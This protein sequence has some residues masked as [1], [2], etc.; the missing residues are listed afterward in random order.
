MANPIGTWFEKNN[1]KKKRFK[2]LYGRK[3]NKEEI[4]LLRKNE[5]DLQMSGAY[6]P[7]STQNIHEGI[8]VK[9]TG[10]ISGIED[11]L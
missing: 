10:M 7:K 6:G 1:F 9:N 2:E 3:P 4:K 11:D 8:S 5:I